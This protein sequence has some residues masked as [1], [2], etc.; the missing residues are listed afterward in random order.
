MRI[1]SVRAVSKQVF[2]GAL[3][4]DWLIQFQPYGYGV[5]GGWLWSWVWGWVC[6]IRHRCCRLESRGVEWR[7]HS[8]NF[9]EK[10]LQKTHRQ[11]DGRCSSPKAERRYGLLHCTHSHSDFFKASSSMPQ[12]S[13]PLFLMIPQ[14]TIVDLT[15][16][17]LNQEFLNLSDH[18]TH[19]HNP[20]KKKG[21]L[22]GILL[23]F[24][25]VTSGCWFTMEG[26]PFL[27]KC[28]KFLKWSM[29]KTK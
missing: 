18:V 22:L 19:Y 7:T 15:G 12:N 26:I 13:N 25:W 1:G 8:T 5:L 23:K 2:V 27:K 3:S 21:E 28:S 17:L 29:E 10:R 20:S 9:S 6:S 4:R 11:K 16:N 14:P 24:S